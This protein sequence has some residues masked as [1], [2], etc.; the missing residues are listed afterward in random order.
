MRVA[1]DGQGFIYALGRFNNG[2]FKFG[3]DGKYGVQGQ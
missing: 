1:V 3:R 2:V